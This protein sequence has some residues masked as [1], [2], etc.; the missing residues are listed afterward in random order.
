MILKREK[1]RGVGEGERCQPV[2]ARLCGPSSF[3][4]VVRC[5]EILARHRGAARLLYV[6]KSLMVTAYECFSVARPLCAAITFRSSEVKACGRQCD[7][8]EAT[9]ARDV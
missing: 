6:L 9:R 3:G 2:C 7:A 1:T 4:V 8:A 5:A